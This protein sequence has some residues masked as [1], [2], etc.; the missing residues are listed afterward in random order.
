MPD[1]TPLISVIIVSWNVADSLKRCLDSVFTTKYSNLEIIVIDNASTDNSLKIAKSFSQT[2]VIAN[3]KNLGFPKSVNIGLRQ[4]RGDYILL[5]NPDTRLPKDFFT[6]SLEFV[7]SHSDLGVMGPKFINPDGTPQGSVFL[8]PSI[9]TTFREYWLGQKGLTAKYSPPGI[10]EVSSVSGACMFFPKTTI[11]KVGKFTE[12]V[13]MYFEDMDY[14]RRIRRAKLKVYY[15]PQI[16]IIHEHGQSSKKLS[17][18]KYRNLIETVVYP[19]RKMLHLPNTTP[20]MERYRTESGIWYNGWF[21]AA[22]LA[23]I[24]WTSHRFLG[25]DVKN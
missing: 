10:A 24:I 14:C 3:T 19:C 17:N 13:F 18:L 6:R 16:T 25:Q 2:N 5:L 21:K 8:E 12:E 4:S 23:V 22:I 9:I 11:V 1:S 7:Y 20:S 15:N